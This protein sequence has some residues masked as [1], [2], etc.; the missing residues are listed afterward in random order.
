M[1]ATV[2]RPL[3]DPRPELFQGLALILIFVGTMSGNAPGASVSH[4]I[5]SCDAAIIFMFVSGY[6]AGLSFGRVQQRQGA[7]FATMQI[8]RQAWLLYVTYIFL[9]AVFAGE[10][11][12]LA[13]LTQKPALIV[14]MGLS[15]FSVAPHI[16]IAKALLLDFQPHPLAIVP[17]LVVLLAAFP[18]ILQLMSRH[19]FLALGPALVV[20][21]GSQIWPVLD[22]SPGLGWHYDP[23]AWQLLFIVGATCGYQVLG[24]RVLVSRRS[25]TIAAAGIVAV[26]AAIDLSWLAH[27]SYAPVPALF[28]NAL[29]PLVDNS[30]LGPLRLINFLALAI[31]VV[32]VLP[33][34]SEM[35]RA[36]WLHP[37]VLC[38]R[39]ATYVLCLAILLGVLGHVVLDHI[40]GGIACGLIIGA[41]G[42]AAM[43]MAALLL[44][45]Y[46][47]AAHATSPRVPP[48]TPTLRTT[49]KT[50]NDRTTEPTLPKAA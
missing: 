26:C 28:F 17:L 38:G 35:I 22:T 2:I 32:R 14:E 47:S 5:W 18:L 49:G 29:R 1:P 41:V 40:D 7:L 36:T 33:R 23:L 30:G 8:C 6:V 25:A 15:Q 21:A 37:L 9:F 42:T 16:A 24:R 48:R 50:N 44:Q 11:S 34:D 46:A 19:G 13:I 45:W 31:L 3:H 39:H 27:Q 20:Y 10:V 12:G 43:T 4:S